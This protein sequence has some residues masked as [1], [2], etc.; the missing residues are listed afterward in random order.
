MKQDRN[1]QNSPSGVK[2]EISQTSTCQIYKVFKGCK[3]FKGSFSS[4][5]TLLC[6]AKNLK[7]ALYLYPGHLSVFV[8]T[9]VCVRVHIKDSNLQLKKDLNK[10]FQ[11]TKQT[12]GILL[13]K[14]VAVCMKILPSN[15]QK[16]FTSISSM[17]HHIQIPK[18]HVH[19]MSLSSY[20]LTWMYVQ[21]NVCHAIQRFIHK[22]ASVQHGY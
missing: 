13:V 8:C 14:S 10:R 21:L 11:Q 5:L 7:L 17:T 15:L 2:T 6:W 22:G 1:V 4:V 19:F 12:W 20:P 16:P 18:M 3:D 9:W